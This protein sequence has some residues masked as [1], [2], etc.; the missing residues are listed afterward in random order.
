M[1]F[2]HQSVG[3]NIVNGIRDLASTDSRLKLTIVK[4]SH[5]ESIAGPA[6][7]EFNVGENGNPQSKIDAF[8]SVLDKG[9]GSQGGIA[10][11]KFCYVDVDLSTD[12]EKLAQAYSEAM[13]TI[14]RKYPRLKIV[15]ITMPL[16]SEEPIAKAWMKRLLGRTTQEELNFKRNQFNEIIRRRYAGVEPVF[17][18]AQAESTHTDGSR[19]FVM[20]GDRCIYTLAPEFTRDGGHLNELGRRLVAQQLLLLLSQ[21]EAK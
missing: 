8:V 18:L 12:V 2:G 16:T 20:R 6:L 14:K 10:M 1:L 9:M 13:D 3:T 5:P 17:D 7:V 11:F 19:S 21:M 15:H 4:S